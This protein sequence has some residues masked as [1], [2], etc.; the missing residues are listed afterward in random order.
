[1]AELLETSDIYHELQRRILE[2][3]Y[4]PGQILSIRKLA[5]EF[6]ISATPVREALLRLEGELLVDRAPNNSARVAEITYKD[7]RDIAEVR[8]SLGRQCGRLAAMRMTE[9]E[10]TVCCKLLEE[11]KNATSFEQVMRSDGRL[12]EVLYAATK[13]AILQRLYL[14]IR[15][16]VS[17]LYD[18]IKEKDAWRGFIYEEWVDILEAVFAGDS[19]RS[20]DLMG[21]HVQ[22]FVT[23]M[24]RMLQMTPPGQT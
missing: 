3:E 2:G 6:G 16:Q 13:N 4:D 8:L 1:M 5:S 18:L 17:H 24:S 12:H 9:A 20:A 11:L 14:Q 21:S 7:I 10:K 19:D 22:H 15:Y 23:E